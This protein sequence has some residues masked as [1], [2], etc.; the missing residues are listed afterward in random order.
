MKECVV[1]VKVC[2]GIESWGVE[3]KFMVFVKSRVS[4]NIYWCSSINLSIIFILTFFLIFC[5]IL[6]NWIYFVG[7]HKSFDSS[8]KIP[9]SSSA[10]YKMPQRPC[11]YCGNFQSYLTRHILM[12]HKDKTDVKYT[13]NLSAKEKRQAFGFLRREGIMKYHP[14]A[15]LRCVKRQKQG[16]DQTVCGKEFLIRN[17]QDEDLCTRRRLKTKKHSGFIYLSNKQTYSCQFL[18]V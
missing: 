15:T 4:M 7:Q 1:D 8:I 10:V 5:K 18:A 6:C 14:Q 13:R 2:E 17:V 12:R 9:S 3:L 16:R 11:P